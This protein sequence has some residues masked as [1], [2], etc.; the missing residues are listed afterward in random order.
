MTKT[1]ITDPELDEDSTQEE[2]ED[3]SSEII[4]QV[5]EYLRVRNDSAYSWIIETRRFIPKGTIVTRG[6]GAGKV[7]DEDTFSKWEHPRY[8]TSLKSAFDTLLTLTL[9][10]GSPTIHT[11]DVA[12]L[13]VA[14]EEATAKLLEVFSEVSNG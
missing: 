3:S 8:Y 9:I 14:L 2:S 10:D 7:Y 11:T 13:V 6:R 5:S 1:R 12:D 4:Y